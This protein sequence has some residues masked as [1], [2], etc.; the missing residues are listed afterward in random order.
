ME[1]GIKCPKKVFQCR[2]AIPCGLIVN[3]LITNYLKHAIPDNI[4]GEITIDLLK[5]D[6]KYV[7]NI[8]DNG[9]GFPDNIDYKNTESLGLQLVTSLVDQ[10][11]GTNRVK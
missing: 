7:L 2:S 3:E 11:D 1:S 9:V 4:N 10:I 8:D 5:I 6:D